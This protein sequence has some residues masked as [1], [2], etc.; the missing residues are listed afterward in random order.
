M[1]SWVPYFKAKERILTYLFA[2]A[3]LL[4][5]SQ[6]HKDL[7][8]SN[9]NRNTGWQD[10]WATS[11]FL[12]SISAFNSSLLSIHFPWLLLNLMILNNFTLSRSFW[13][14]DF[15]SEIFLVLIALPVVA[16]VNGEIILSNGFFLLL[17][18][19]PQFGSL[20]CSHFQP[21]RA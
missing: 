10:C 2:Q 6:R 21:Q 14:F 19:K 16:F 3:A 15:L 8:L 5:H 11:Y 13:A 20:H 4:I 9:C 7:N 12:F 17:S 1:P 18:L